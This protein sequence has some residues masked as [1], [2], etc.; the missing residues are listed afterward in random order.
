MQKKYL[1]NNRPGLRNGYTTFIVN[2][3]Q[4][5]N[6]SA[7]NINALFCVLIGA[8]PPFGVR[9]NFV[10]FPI[11]FGSYPYIQIINYTKQKV[12]GILKFLKIPL[13]IF[14]CLCVFLRRRRGFLSDSDRYELAVRDAVYV[15]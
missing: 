10:L 3:M 9:A 13:F 5:I 11:L 4:S 12:K 1:V 14:F 15:V 2:K 6:T 7:I 8:S